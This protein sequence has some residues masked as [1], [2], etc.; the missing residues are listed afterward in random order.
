MWIHKLRPIEDRPTPSPNRCRTAVS[1]VVCNNE[2]VRYLRT[3]IAGLG[4]RFARGT[5]YRHSARLVGLV[6]FQVSEY[7]RGFDSLRQ[8]RLTFG[9]DGRISF[10]R[11]FLFSSAADCHEPVRRRAPS[12]GGLAAMAW[13]GTG[14]RVARR[15]NRHFI[16]SRRAACDLAR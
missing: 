8:T 9:C 7:P 3:S 15:W 2:R 12:S 11:V 13:P 4:L 1:A 10:L 5:N 16:S 6:G 14:Q